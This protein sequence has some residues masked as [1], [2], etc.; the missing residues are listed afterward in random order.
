[1][2]R[3][4]TILQVLSVLAHGGSER[5]ALAGARAWVEAGGRSIMVGASGS[6]E[7]EITAAGVEI[8]HLPL[9][10]NAPWKVLANTGRLEWLMQAESVAAVHWHNRAPGWSAYRAARRLRIPSFST[11]HSL[12]GENVPGK[13]WWNSAMVRGDVAIV[14]SRHAAAEVERRH[15]GVGGRRLLIPNGV[16]TTA[17][18]PERVSEPERAALRAIMGA[19]EDAFLVSLPARFTRLKGHLV[20]IE[21]LRQLAARGDALTRLAFVGADGSAYVDEVREAARR[22][23][24]AERVAILLARDDMPAVLAASDLVLSP[25]TERESFALVRVEAGAME[26]VLI[27]TRIGAAEEIVVTDPGAETG[28]LVP[29]GDASAL[30][31]GI[32]WGRDL[33]PVGRAAVGRRARAHVVGH[34]DVSSALQMLVDAYAKATGGLT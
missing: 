7:P 13:R 2:S 11:Y 8:R 22:A 34:F 33:G 15:A 28:A 29:T 20:A 14:T 27:A 16:D 12:Y 32:A 31:A 3:R 1:M 17:F 6:L 19:G 10:G 9:E 5:V 18:A 4:P 24:L 21:A 30:A 26:R 23:G 25:S